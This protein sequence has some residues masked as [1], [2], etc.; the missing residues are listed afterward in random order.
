MKSVRLH[1]TRDSVGPGDD[2]LAPHERT[3]S[4]TGPVVAPTDLQ[5]AVARVAPDYLPWAMGRVTWG[6]WCGVP[7]GIISTRGT[8]FRPFF[9]SDVDAQRFSRTL[10]GFELQF[11]YFGERDPDVVFDVLEQTQ[12]VQPSRVK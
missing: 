4:V 2:M 1:L 6:A 11:I 9:L 10:D 8:L 7:L 3:V 12:R 5:D